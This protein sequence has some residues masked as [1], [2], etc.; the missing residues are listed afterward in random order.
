MVTDCGLA[1]IIRRQQS[2]NVADALFPN[3]RFPRCFA[4]AKRYHG[5]DDSAVNTEERSRQ[6]ALRVSS[7][8]EIHFG[9]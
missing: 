1:R 5:G 7:G 6:G 9:T 2:D 4:Q 8:F 3:M